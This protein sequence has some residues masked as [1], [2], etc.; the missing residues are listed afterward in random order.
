MFVYWLVNRGINGAPMA[1]FARLA[2]SPIESASASN[3][4]P[5]ERSH[6]I[7]LERWEVYAVAYRAD[8][9]HAH[10]LHATARTL[11]TARWSHQAWRVS[12][13]L[14]WCND[15][16]ETVLLELRD[17]LQ[18]LF[19]L[20][21]FLLPLVHVVYALLGPESLEHIEVLIA[22]LSRLS[23]PLVIVETPVGWARPRGPWGVA[24]L[25]AHSWLVARPTLADVW[26][27][28]NILAV[29][30]RVGEHDGAAW[31]LGHLRLLWHDRRH[32]LK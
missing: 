4:W 11:P 6:L 14:Y 32:L 2:S 7:L 27:V 22:D 17:V 5:S 26:L 12:S 10:V 20:V 21:V 3:W 1:A 8:I 13:L 31:V 25:G 16:W 24:A 23:L 29:A 30:T 15:V 18:I 28:L 19:P 9:L